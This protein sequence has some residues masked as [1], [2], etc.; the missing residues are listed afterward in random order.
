MNTDAEGDGPE[1]EASVIH[2]ASG[3]GLMDSP[4]GVVRVPAGHE[5]SSERMA[6]TAISESRP[7]GAFISINP[8]T[9]LFLPPDLA[10]RLAILLPPLAMALAAWNQL[11]LELGEAAVYVGDGPV[12]GLLGQ[13]ALW[14]GAMPVLEVG[15][16]QSEW[17]TPGLTAICSSSADKLVAKIRSSTSQCPGFAAIDTSGSPD[18]LEVLL[19][20]LPKWGRFA[21]CARVSTRATVDFYN[22]V[23]R[24]GARIVGATLDPM[25]LFD[26]RH[27]SRYLPLAIRALNILSDPQLSN[28]CRKFADARLGVHGNDS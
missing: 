26:N 23:H 1:V 24:K 22:N 13:A 19:D 25:L 11:S 12:S 18:M 8:S 17:A 6:L 14:R 21:L 9:C 3:C 15:I 10:P 2:T 7:Y 27:R 28:G 4:F 16:R 5:S 20:A